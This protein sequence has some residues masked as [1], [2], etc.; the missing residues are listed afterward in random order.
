MVLTRGLVL[1]SALSACFFET[2]SYSPTIRL[3]LVR[4]THNVFTFIIIYNT[5]SP[6]S[7]VSHE[8]HILTEILKITVN[9]LK[10]I[11]FA[12]WPIR[13]RMPDTVKILFYFN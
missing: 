10:G 8:K 6:P 11:S 2:S 7:L 4:P 3:F 5:V 12:W 13:S 1:R 9:F